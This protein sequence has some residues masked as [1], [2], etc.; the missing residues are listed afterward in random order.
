MKLLVHRGGIR[1]LDSFRSSFRRRELRWR[2]GNHRARLHWS[3]AVE[4]YWAQIATLRW[5]RASTTLPLLSGG[6]TG[7]LASR[8][9]AVRRL[10]AQAGLSDL[11]RKLEL[12]VTPVLSSHFGRTLHAQALGL[13]HALVTLSS[14]TSGSSGAARHEPPRMPRFQVGLVFHLRKDRSTDPWLHAR[15]VRQI[16]AWLRDH[17]GYEALVVGLDAASGEL[18]QPPSDFVPAFRLALEELAGSEGPYRR[19][20]T[21]GLTFHVGEDFRDLLTGI[22]QVDLALRLLLLRPGDRLGHALALGLDPAFW[23]QRQGGTSVLQIGDH[24]LDLLWARHLLRLAPP[25]DG[26]LSG[27]VGNRLERL[28]WR[29]LDGAQAVV[30]KWLEGPYAREIERESV[31]KQRLVAHLATG[32]RP[33]SLYEVEVSDGWIAIVSAM[34]SAVARSVERQGICIEANPSSNLAISGLSRL[35]DL[36]LF[37]QHPILPSPSA[38]HPPLRLSISTDDPGLF[39][40]GPREEYGLLFATA[41]DQATHTRE[42]VLSWLDR[43]RGIGYESSFLLGRAA[44]G[45]QFLEYLRQ[46]TAQRSRPAQAR[47]LA[48]A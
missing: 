46:L 4:R 32:L 8:G 19:P 21:L 26:S 13:S 18:D 48:R 6:Q 29:D 11:E 40:T 36:P 20:L 43:L 22:R 38:P 1:G 15:A 27:Q 37:R 9:L 42:E 24:L 31:L 14:A 17:P 47:R 10:G 7:Q 44:T 30:T 5:M 41:L 28:G 3:L 45:E 25:M 39:Q 23:Y 2:G 33:E 16:F 34:Q 35:E 12:R